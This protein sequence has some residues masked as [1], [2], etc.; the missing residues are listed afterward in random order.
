MIYTVQKD[1]ATMTIFTDVE[2]LGKE[3]RYILINSIDNL[4]EN[5]S[6]AWNNLGDE[7]QVEPSYAF[8]C[9]LYESLMWDGEIQ[10]LAKAYGLEPLDLPDFTTN[11]WWD[12]SDTSGMK[13]CHARLDEM[14]AWRDDLYNRIQTT[15][16]LK[17]FTYSLDG[18]NRKTGVEWVHKIKVGIV[19]LE[20]EFFNAPRVVINQTTQAREYEEWEKQ[21]NSE[22]GKAER[23]AA[24]K[25]QAEINMMMLENGWHNM[26][27]D[28]EGNIT[29]W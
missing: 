25:R 24:A 17:S 26:S 23:K 7:Y 6:Y 11:Q 12:W 21:Y 2:A 15:F 1:D 13:N 9:M 29:M 3:L 5:E 16:P 8:A 20:K 28:G 22:E 18:W 10:N 4:T 27:D 19:D 14:V